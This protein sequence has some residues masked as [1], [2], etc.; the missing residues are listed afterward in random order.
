MC[1]FFLLF[2][3]VLFFHRRDLIQI[4]WRNG[5]LDALFAR[6]CFT[7]K[8]GRQTRLWGSLVSSAGQLSCR[9]SH[10]QTYSCIVVGI[11]RMCRGVRASASVEGRSPFEQG[12]LAEAQP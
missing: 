9:I 12:M 10:I 8:C 11:L 4:G 3:Y 2:L 1:I 7:G 5:G 6:I